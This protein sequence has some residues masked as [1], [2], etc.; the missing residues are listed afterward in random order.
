MTK[1]TKILIAA[2]V[3]IVGVMAGLF[4]LANSGSNTPPVGDKTKITRPDSHKTGSGPVTMVEFGD[5]QCPA[6]GAAYPNVKQLLADYNGKVTF[7][8]RNFPLTNLHPNAMASAQAAE[9]AGD[10]G[11]YWQ[12]HDMLYENQKDWSTVT[13]PTSTFVNYAQSLGL[14]TTK[15]RNAIINKEF[16]SVIDQDIADGTALNIQ[17]TP[18]FYFNGTAYSGD[19][20]YASLKNKVDALL[21]STSAASASPSPSASPAASPQP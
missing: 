17:G 11:K 19:S 7:Y 6:C 14:D 3:V 9:A 21:G 16:Q 20:S 2:L 15:F 18:T 1:E 5:Y 12:M 4:M 10:Q 8:F 13:D